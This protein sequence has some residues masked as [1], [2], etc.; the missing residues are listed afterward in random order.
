MNIGKDLSAVIIG[1][2]VIGLV[3]LII[4]IEGSGAVPQELW[5]LATTIV[6]FVLRGQLDPKLPATPPEPISSYFLGGQVVTGGSVGGVVGDQLN[7]TSP[8]SDNKDA[9]LV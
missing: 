8:T 4:A 3:G 7:V 6:G 5:L 2:A 9:P 1:L